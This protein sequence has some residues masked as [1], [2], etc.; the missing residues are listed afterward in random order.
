MGLD[1]IGYVLRKEILE[2]LRVVLRWIGK[3]KE[4]MVKG[5]MVEVRGK[6]NER[7]GIDL[8]YGILDVSR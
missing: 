3:K 8:R 5:D 7:L 6:G 2:M 1:W 4:R